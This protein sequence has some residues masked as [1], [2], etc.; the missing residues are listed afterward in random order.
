LDP[1]LD[2][3]PFGSAQGDVEEIAHAQR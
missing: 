2:D 3:G 1:S